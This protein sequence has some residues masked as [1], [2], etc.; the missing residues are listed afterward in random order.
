MNE[1]RTAFFE[2]YSK[3]RFNA[4]PE[5]LEAMHGAIAENGQTKP[6]PDRIY[7]SQLMSPR[8]DIYH[9][10]IGTE[11]DSPT[12]AEVMLTADTGKMLELMLVSM[13]AKDGHIRVPS[14]EQEYLTYEH[15]GCRFVGRLD[16]TGLD[17]SPIEIKTEHNEGGF[18]IRDMEK[19]IVKEKYLAQIGLYC[20]ALGKDGGTLII[21]NRGRGHQFFLDVYLRDGWVSCM[22]TSVHIGAQLDELAKLMRCNISAGIE[23]K[24]DFEYH[25]HLTD[26]LLAGFSKTRI[27]DAIQGRR[28]LSG[29]P[30]YPQY[31]SYKHRWI[32][33]EANDK[34]ADPESLMEY[35][36]DEIE[37][38]KDY[39]KRKGIK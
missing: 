10:C 16:A 8:F 37:F 17:G 24:P 39:C 32:E 3:H 31:S 13:L 30:Y 27:K 15:N 1:Y 26:D 29:H 7:A 14:A 5:L 4:T 35:S 19:G 6:H 22:D 12:S 2:A 28:I 20:L 9:S 34:M 33:R 21:I 11:P 38:L 23:P 18:M 36:R 25:P